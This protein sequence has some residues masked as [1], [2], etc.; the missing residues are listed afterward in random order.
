MGLISRVSSR[1]YRS[2][3]KSSLSQSCLLTRKDEKT[4]NTSQ[5]QVGDL[6]TNRVDSHQVRNSLFTCHQVSNQ[7]FLQKTRNDCCKWAMLLLCQ[8]ETVFLKIQILGIELLTGRMIGFILRIL[9]L[10]TA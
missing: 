8:R 5:F 6:A 7:P 10:L 3:K 1:T 4:W 2:V 9:E